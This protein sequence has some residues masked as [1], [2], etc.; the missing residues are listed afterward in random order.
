MKIGKV[1]LLVWIVLMVLWVSINTYLIYDLYTRINN[2][3]AFML[4]LHT[5]EL[6]NGGI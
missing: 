1:I 3:A 4:F 6:Y 5:G 2:I